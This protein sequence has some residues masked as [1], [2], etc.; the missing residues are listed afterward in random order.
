MSDRYTPTE[1]K[2]GGPRELRISWSDGHVSVYD[3]AYLRRNCRCAACVDEWSGSRILQPHEIPEDVKP[4]T[5]RRVG[6]YA[7]HFEW[8]DGHTSGIYSFEHLRNI[9]PCS[10]CREST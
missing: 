9:C 7:V 3:V 4:Q 10:E 2:Q 6:R 1:I 5:V 8:S